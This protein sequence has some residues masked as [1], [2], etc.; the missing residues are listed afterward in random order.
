MPYN[1]VA[2]GIHAK[3]LVADFKQSAILPEK[4][5][6]CTFEPPLG[7]GLRGNIRSSS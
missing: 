7:A 5:P 6:F 2:Y 4:W 3:K 1:S